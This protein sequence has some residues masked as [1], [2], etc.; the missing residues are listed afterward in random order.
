M[1][2][3]L[4][5]ILKDLYELDPSL[6]EQEGEVRLL[7]AAL[8]E[9]RPEAAVPSKA[10][11][12][13]LRQ[14]L[15][16]ITP[17]AV[18]TGLFVL[19]LWLRYL[20]PVG[21]VAVLVFVLVPSPLSSP[22]AVTPAVTPAVDEVIPV[23][24]FD[25]G[26]I[27]VRELEMSDLPQGKLAAP[28][29]DTA[30]PTADTFMRMEMAA[31][32]PAVL[33]D[34]FTIITQVPGNTVTVESVFLSAPGFIFIIQ[35]SS[36]NHP[37]MIGVSQLLPPGIINKVRINLYEPIMKGEV[38]NAVLYYDNGDGVFDG[39]DDRLTTYEITGVTGIGQTF[40]VE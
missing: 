3:Q 36:E 30:V 4:D 14:E 31:D 22:T 5:N 29:A 35:A 33:G 6:R 2:D 24:G 1:N 11:A 20:A 17:G 25:E 27:E 19:P 23:P 39:S 7:V 16:A 26:M 37:Y 18:P 38:L 32:A 10:F 28:A 9:A 15:L 34:S 40:S 8:L 21:F 13:K 12:A